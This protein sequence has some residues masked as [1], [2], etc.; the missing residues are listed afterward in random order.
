MTPSRLAALAQRYARSLRLRVLTLTLGIFAAIAVPA[1]L[2][3]V[4]VID[5]SI[6]KLGTLFAEKQVLYDRYRGLETLMRETGLAETLARAPAMLDWAADENEPGRRERG[7]R[8]LEHYRQAF[9]DRSAF[10]VMDGSGNYYFGDHDN[11]VATGAAPRYAVRR[12]NPRDGWYFATRAAGAGCHLNVDHDD[13]L[14]V[15]KVW[16]N[17]V[18]TQG[19]RPVGIIGTGID[20]STFVTEVVNTNQPGVQSI[21]VDRSGAV[22]ASRDRDAIDFHSL[23]RDPGTRKTV[24]QM[25]DD[26]AGRAALA[27]MFNRA[28]TGG[29]VAVDFVEIGGKRMLVGIGWLDRLGW[30]NVTVMDVDAII[31][32]GLFRPLAA[33]LLIALLGA[34]VLVTWLFKRAVLDRLGK[35]EEA[36]VKVERGDYRLDAPDR[37]AD[38]IG[39]LSRAFDQMAGRVARTTADLETA[40]RERTQKLEEI[41]FIDPLT[42]IA[43]R[44]GFTDAW[45]SAMRRA[46]RTGARPGLLL[47]DID[48]FKDV[49]DSHGHS[50]GDAIMTESARRI[51]ATLREADCCGRWGGDEFVVLLADCDT[52]GLQAAALRVLNAVRGQPFELAS[53]QKI[54][55]TT[56]VGGHLACEGETLESAAHKAD[57]ALYG[58]KSA[59]RNRLVVYE[60]GLPAHPHHP[61]PKDTPVHKD[62]RVA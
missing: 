36:V 33:I 26:Q 47:L 19:G 16:I 62:A 28:A 14:A 12:D 55:L 22:Q 17:C 43:N 25:A 9:A 1:C 11:P 34:A 57:V 3:F 61:V 44:R 50:A 54:R 21:F 42:G 32:R 48:N 20:L 5:H 60:P 4:Q 58:A 49:N 56:S 46:R 37:G 53:G 8:E 10:V 52:V 39:R 38:E 30:Y 13:V 24:F 15:T 45:T 35:V 59:G 51:A 18:M 7:L 40:V 27:R 29:N 23:T 41:A 2:V 6:V 31:D